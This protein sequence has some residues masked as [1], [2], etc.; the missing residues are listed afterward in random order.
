MSFG[1]AELV[2]TYVQAHLVDRQALAEAQEKCNA[3]MEIATLKDAFTTDV[4]P[5][6]AMARERAG[7]ALHTIG[8]I[9][10]ANI[11]SAR[12]NNVRHRSA[13]PPASSEAE[14]RDW[15]LYDRHTMIGIAWLA[16]PAIPLRPSSQTNALSP[17]AR[18]PIPT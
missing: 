8:R 10:Q 12:L 3:L 13:L 2:L 1:A 9:G 14:A 17:N 7:G 6:L 11:A 15:R 4:S 18:P 5:I 16:V